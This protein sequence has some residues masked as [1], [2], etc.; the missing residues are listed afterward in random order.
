ME[1]LL[2][3][4]KYVKGDTYANYKKI[5]DVAKKL[6]GKSIVFIKGRKHRVFA[7]VEKTVPYS[8]RVENKKLGE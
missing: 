8:L 4:W 6:V 2:L 7:Q 1:D 5:Q 3:E